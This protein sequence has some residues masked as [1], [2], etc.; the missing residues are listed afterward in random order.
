EG[1]LTIS[2]NG[3]ILLAGHTSPLDPA[4]FNAQLLG[5][6][7]DLVVRV[8]TTS[9]DSPWQPE[10]RLRGRIDD[11]DGV[12]HIGERAL[13]DYLSVFLE[14]RVEFEVT[15]AHQLFAE[16]SDDPNAST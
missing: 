6:D 11:Q 2:P 12:L 5:E 8:V 13:K 4:V 1:V 16:E 9:T 3:E 10:M 7:V 15:R 14:R